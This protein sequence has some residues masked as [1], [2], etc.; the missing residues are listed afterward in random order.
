[1]KQIAFYILFLA[2]SFLGFAQI[3]K[4]I[5]VQTII[6][7][8]DSDVIKNSPI[9]V[10]I[11]IIDGTPVGEPLYTEVHDLTSTELG[12]LNLNIGTGNNLQPRIK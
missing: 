8:D 12:H 5:S 7:D 4:P 11:S 1:M 2:T 9:G 10:Q 6:M 3:P